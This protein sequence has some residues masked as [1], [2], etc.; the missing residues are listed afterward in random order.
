[1]MSILGLKSMAFSSSLTKSMRPVEES[2][3]YGRDSKKMEVA[4][5]FLP[6]AV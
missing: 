4:D 6:F 3:L 1:M 5:I 2:T